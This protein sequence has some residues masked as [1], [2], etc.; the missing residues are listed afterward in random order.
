MNKRI[1]EWG[2][3]TLPYCRILTNK[4]R[5]SPLA[6]TTADPKIGG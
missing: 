6:T 1:N 5:K 3:G 2:E 4:N